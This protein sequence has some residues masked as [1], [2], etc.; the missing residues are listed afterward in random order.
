MD[1]SMI[2]Q[3]EVDIWVTQHP[4]LPAIFDPAF[5][6]VLEGFT[7]AE[8]GIDITKPIAPQL[9]NPPRLPSVAGPLAQL[10]LAFSGPMEPEDPAVP[11]G[12]QRFAFPF[13]VTL[14]DDTVFT[15]V[16]QN[17]TLQATFT[18]STGTTVSNKGIIQ[19]TK[20]PNPY[21]LH[22]D[23][24]LHPPL[25]WYLSVDIRVFQLKAGQPMFETAIGSSGAASTV[26][27]GYIQ[28]VIANLNGDVGNSRAT[29]DG[30]PQEEDTAVL[31]LS[32]TDPADGQPVGRHPLPAAARRGA[33]GRAIQHGEPAI[34]PTAVHAQRA[35]LPDRRGC[36][37]SRSDPRLG[38]PVHLRQTGAAQP[39][40]R[41]RTQPR[42]HR[43]APGAADLRAQAD[44][45][46][47]HARHA[48]R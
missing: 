10:Q 26:A 31:S 44:R 30:L 21:I 1:N 14:H 8:L 9:A 32:P 37:R 46:G 27:T 22:S 18:S 34:V 42:D 29:F 24:T 23:R 41:G 5:K 40:I 4:P 3:G 6:V 11:P 20:K 13:K 19:L 16:D 47:S 15:T 45:T 38:R 17:V 39:G 33:A 48:A 12:P 35:S 2:S 36:L 7:P 28:S 25:P 43:V